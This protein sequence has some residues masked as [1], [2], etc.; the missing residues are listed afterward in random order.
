MENWH[1]SISIKVKSETASSEEFRVINDLN[2]TP[3]GLTLDEGG[4]CEM[5]LTPVPPTS[6]TPAIAVKKMRLGPSQSMLSVPNGICTKANQLSESRVGKRTSTL[7][8][9]LL[10]PKKHES[11]PNPVL[12]SIL[13]LMF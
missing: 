9:T 6:V 10:W 1:S 8:L 4:Q 2:E 3:V 11:S 12:I 5:I 13:L 7:G